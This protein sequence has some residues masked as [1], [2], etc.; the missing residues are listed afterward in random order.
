MADTLSVNRMCDWDPMQ[1]DYL[2]GKNKYSIDDEDVGSAFHGYGNLWTKYIHTYAFSLKVTFVPVALSL[3]YIRLADLCRCVH[4]SV[5][6][7]A[8]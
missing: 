5:S 3:S 8:L 7:V 4:V 1:A 6:A 2:S